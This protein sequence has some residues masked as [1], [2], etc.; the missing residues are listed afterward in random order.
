MLKNPNKLVLTQSV[1]CYFMTILCMIG[2]CFW[3]GAWIEIGYEFC[4]FRC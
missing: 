2:V 3:F 1:S 4:Q